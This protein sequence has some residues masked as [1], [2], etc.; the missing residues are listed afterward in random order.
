MFRAKFFPLLPSVLILGA[1]AV[2]PPAGPTVLALPPEGKDLA[3]FQQDDGTCRG[4]AQQQI[5]Y[6]SPQQAADQSA[7]GSAAVG[8]VVGAAAGAAIGAAAG[9]AGTGAAIGAG[10]GLLAGSAVGVG[11]AS[12]SAAGLQQRYD[13]AYAQCMASRGDRVQGFPIAGAYGPYGYPYAYPA[14]YDSWFGPTLGL[15]F[16]GTVDHHHHFHHHDFS[17]H[18]FNR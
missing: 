16:F 18:A 8:T 12:A 14:Y 2:V 5:G 9:S 10:T 17:H 11:N 15:G 1:C 3:L 13:T 4:Y 7:I 6:G